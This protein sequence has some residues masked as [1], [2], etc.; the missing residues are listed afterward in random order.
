MGLAAARGLV[1]PKGPGLKVERRI[2]QGELPP[3]ARAGQKLGAIEVFVDGRSLGSSALVAEKGYEE[4][5]LWDKARYAMMWPAEKLWG[6]L[7]SRVAA[8]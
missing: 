7:S 1:G 2:T 6:W 4:A 5:S 3:S 8:P